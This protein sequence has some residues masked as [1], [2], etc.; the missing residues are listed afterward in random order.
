MLMDVNETLAAITAPG[1]FSS[2]RTSS[3]DDLHV[4]VKGVGAIDWPVSAETARKLRGVAR[5]AGYGWRDKTFV[6]QNVRNTWEIAKS[7]VKIDKRKWKNTLGP[8][9]QLIQNDLGL[10]DGGKLEARLYKMLLYEPGQFFVPHQDS[11]KSDDMVG[12]LTVILPSAY[13]GG[14]TSIELR[15]EK[16]TYRP[17]RS[18]DKRLTFVA[19]YSDCHHEV[20]PIKDGHRVVLVYDLVFNDQGM[21]SPSSLFD[22]QTLDEL[23]QYIDAHFSTSTPARYS[24]NPTTPPDKLVYLLDHEYTRRSLGWNR[25]KNGDRFRALAL[26]YAAQRLDCELFLALADV[27]ETWSCEGDDYYDGWRY[28]GYSRG[29]YHEVDDDPESYQL[30]DM[31]ESDIELRHWLDS[32][33]KS[34]RAVNSGVDWDEVCFTRPSVDFDPFQSEHEGW[35]GNYGNTVDRWY[36][37]A[38]VVLW[39]RERTFVIRAKISPMWAVDQLAK[40]TGKGAD[41]EAKLKARALQPFW[42]YCAPREA[43]KQFSERTLEVANSLD[44]AELA[45][46]LLAPLRLGQLSIVGLSYFLGLLRSHGQNWCWEL[47]CNW[48]EKLDRFGRDDGET[49]WLKFMPRFCRT[50]HEEGAVSGQELARRVIVH[51]WSIIKK[52]CEGQLEDLADPYAVEQLSSLSKKLA[53]V[54]R[55]CVAVDNREV[56]EDILS[57]LTSEDTRYPIVSILPL[58]HESRSGH[59]SDRNI[60]PPRLEVLH[61][62]CMDELQSRL[63]TSA[64]AADDWSMIPPTKCPCDLCMELGEFLSHRDQIRFEWPLATDKRR[65]VHNQL[66]RYKL[67]V[68]HTTRRE[69]RPY[70]LVLVKTKALFTQ[71]ADLRQRYARELAWLTREQD[72]FKESI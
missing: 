25:L 42:H 48:A 60:G 27:H 8:Q 29:R 28:R 16:V 33:G 55:S 56:H 47:Y 52:R 11:E 57:F 13:K 65:H 51:Q 67:P 23:A 1:S 43:A 37:R 34:I 62:Y 59:P 4:E 36:H 40:L 3:P 24:S 69:G 31:I 12:T 39:P 2:R 7:R 53:P 44:D 15:G 71:D 38:A 21:E 18:R 5:R 9:L 54:L 46:S 61:R 70:T 30:L 17:S 45:S 66:D 10:P 22:E 19:F 72:F 32:R 26:R 58:L 6:D 14:S 63:A 49:T 20:H 35:M 50:L 64:R 68:T 41:E